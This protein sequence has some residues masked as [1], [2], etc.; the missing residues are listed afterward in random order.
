MPPFS[1]ARPPAFLLF[2]D[3]PKAGPYLAA[4]ARRGLRSLVVTGP[5]QW[6]LEHVAVS[7]VGR[8][9]HPF[10]AVE[11]LDFRAPEDLSAILAQ[12]ARWASEYDIQGVFAS[13]ET[14]VEPAGQSADLLGLPGVGL[15]AA[16][17]CRNK[18]LQRLYLDEWSPVSVLAS[19]GREAVLT[20]LGERYP[21]ISKPLDLYCSIGVRVLRDRE[22]LEAHLDEVV[23]GPPVLLEQR[24]SGRE[25]SVESIIAG[26]RVV[27]SSVTQKSTNEDESDFF[28]EMGHTVPA[29][30]LSPAEAE[31][32]RQAQAAILARL[33]FGTG[34]AHGEYRIL[35]DGGVALMEIAARPP[36]DGLM[37]VYHLA[38]G[39]S[40]EASVIDAALGL[41]VEHPQPRRWARQI[42]FD[43]DP[44]K[45][46]GVA[47]AGSAE[48]EPFWVVDHGLWPEVE[49][50]APGAPPAL[51]KLLVLKAPGAELGP[52]TDSFG[53]VVTALFDAPDPEQLERFD[54]ATREAVRV[55]VN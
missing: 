15:R 42:Y 32:L 22:A 23:S 4:I 6:P 24:V 21:V 25:F 18:Q 20:A 31:R 30:N 27:F 41:P 37:H 51:R 36:G 16:R 38:T 33:D 54:A 52:L 14:F 9:G 28:V 17:V 3:L 47:V 44:G 39:A 43:H 8:P 50:V 46:A 29:C 12:V 19:S 40:I 34:M 13:S 53:R 7:Y 26:G 48:V 2:T 10:E 5:P 1:A 55:L 35:P 49:P 45:L 11:R